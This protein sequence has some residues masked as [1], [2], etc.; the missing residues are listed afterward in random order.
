[1]KQ[2][3]KEYVDILTLRKQED[4]S[5]AVEALLSGKLAVMK[6]GSIFSLFFN[7]QCPGLADKLNRLKMREVSQS[8][9]LLCTCEQAMSFADKQRVNPDFFSV[10]PGLCHKVLARFPVNTALDLPFPYNTENGTVQFYSFEA[11]HPLLW[12]FQQQLFASGCPC[13]SG[14]SANIHGAPTIE[15]LSD[16]KRLAVLFNIETDFWSLGIESVLINVPAAQGKNQGSF[17]ILGFGNP[18][19]IEVLRL[20]KDRDTTE[21]YLAP[22]M[23]AQQ[24]QTPLAWRQL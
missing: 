16:A 4:I 17:P 21:K 3:A 13:L 19:A 24:F 23:E 14:T 6:I 8:L 1:M 9:S 22:L 18:A 5:Q 12:A 2:N 10:T 20:M 7:P 15:T 11:A